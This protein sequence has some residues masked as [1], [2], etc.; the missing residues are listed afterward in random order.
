MGEKLEKR[1]QGIKKIEK[2]MKKYLTG[3]DDDN[4]IAKLAK[5]ASKQANV[6]LSLKD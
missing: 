2:S 4:T 3:G 5:Q 6:Y 1:K